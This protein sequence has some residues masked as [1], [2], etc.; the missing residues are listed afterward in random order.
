METRQ[1]SNPCPRTAALRR[2][3]EKTMRTFIINE[4]SLPEIEKRVRALNKKAAKLGKDGI[5]FR[6]VRK[7]N[8]RLR[9]KSF[10]SG[11]SG[12]VV[13][14][15]AEIEVGGTAPVILGYRFVAMIRHTG[16]GNIVDVSP[17]AEGLDLTAYRKAGAVCAHCNLT[18]KR[19][20]TFVLQSVATGR[21]IQVGST[22]IDDF[23]G[24]SDVGIALDVWTL[25]TTLSDLER[26]RD[27]SDSD[28]EGGMGGGRGTSAWDLQD[29]L[30]AA[31]AEIRAFG[32]ISRAK[33]DETMM[34][35]TGQSV[36]LYLSSPKKDAKIKP[37]EKDKTD[38]L[39][40]TES[41][42]EL[43][44]PMSDF[45]HN[46]TVI[47][48]SGVVT[49]RDLGYVAAAAFMW[50]KKA[51]EAAA[52][53]ASGPPVNEWVGNVKDKLVLTGMVLQK[54]MVV[55]LD[56]QYGP[57]TMFIWKDPKGREFKW[58][59]SGIKTGPQFETIGSVQTVT[60]T[61]KGH[62]EYKGV[63]STDLTRCKVT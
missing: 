50:K 3:R 28:N 7:F 1:G 54:R 12:I 63:K 38:A 24:S 2:E 53:A 46:L 49:R 37:T 42:L 43:K 21:F 59:A 32:Y 8:E 11:G 35:T 13:L 25:L 36:D 14:R 39:A 27:I 52:L 31:L 20:E 62:S 48:R 45:E 19:H 23:L 51:D 40:V 33:A 60:G 57:S 4:W 29:F 30:T 16:D 10:E 56:S 26:A 17:E 55:G 61:V 41:V 44:D 34:L 9:P 15:R 5:T 18:R 22:C 47:F 58:F 6:V